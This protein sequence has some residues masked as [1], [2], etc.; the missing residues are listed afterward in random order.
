VED[1]EEDWDFSEPF[2]FIY[3]RM[4]AG[5][6]TDWPKFMQRSLECVRLPPPIS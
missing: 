3:G 5:A 2:D 1:L 4:L 6:L